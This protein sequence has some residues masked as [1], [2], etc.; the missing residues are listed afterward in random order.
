M[1]RPRQTSFD[2]PKRGGKR[3]GAGRPRLHEHP[4]LVG[5]GVPHRTRKAFKTCKAVHVTHR[6]RPGVGYLRKDGPAQVLLRAFRAAAS[7]GQM[8]IAH[9]SIQGNHLHFVVEADG[10]Q[11]LSRGMQGLAIRIARR[12]NARLR[13]QGPV[14]ADRYHAR[15]LS[16]PR[17]AANAIRYVAGNYRHHTREWLPNDFV[18]PLASDPDAPL[19][20]VRGWLLR[21][22][23]RDQARRSATPFEPP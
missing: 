17:Q 18:D 12:L 5:P 11:A 1:G 14:F 3:R 23:W 7:G 16:S 4:G 22:G 20:P 19:E 6:I 21:V 8:R 15:L 13:R 2:F 9:Y 10:A